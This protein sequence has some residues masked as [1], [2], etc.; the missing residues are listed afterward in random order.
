[1]SRAPRR[2]QIGGNAKAIAF[3][4]LL[5]RRCKGGD[6]YLDP[7]GLVLPRGLADVDRI[8]PRLGYDISN[9]HL[10]FGPLDRLRNG[11]PD[12]HVARAPRRPHLLSRS[13]SPV[14][15]AIHTLFDLICLPRYTDDSV[16]AEYIE[17]VRAAMAAR[18]AVRAM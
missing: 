16:K 15:F 4:K 18:A 11:N 13:Q 2:S 7:T 10:L 9:L 8:D 17:G 12:C 6:E 3:Y 5:L 14:S 1:M